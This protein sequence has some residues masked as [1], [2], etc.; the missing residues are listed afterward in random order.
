MGFDDFSFPLII[1]KIFG[2][3][4]AAFFSILLLSKTREIHWLLIILG[5]IVMY[6]E[7]II[8]TLFE[9]KILSGDYFIVLGLPFFEIFKIVLVNLP[10]VLFS[11]A[12]LLLFLRKR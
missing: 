1:S 10:L 4:I 12:F 5:T 2:G 7:I 6:I 3:G 11:I 8:S 9:L